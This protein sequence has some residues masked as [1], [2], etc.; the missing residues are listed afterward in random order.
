MISYPYS[1]A[2]A[3]R[4]FLTGS[5]MRFALSTAVASLALLSLLCGS[6]V[7]QRRGRREIE[8]LKE[9]AD[10]GTLKGNERFLRENRARSDYVGPDR[11]ELDAFIGRVQGRVD[12]P[13]GSSIDGVRRRVDRSETVN[14]PLPPNGMFQMYHPRID[15]NLSDGFSANPV[16]GDVVA[17]SALDTLVDS[18]RLSGS[19]R[20]SVSVVDRTAILRGEVPS[21]GARRTAALLLSFEPGISSIQNELTVNPQLKAGA[22]SLQ[23]LRRREENE[24]AWMTLSQAPTATTESAESAQ[25]AS[26]SSGSR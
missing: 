17:S 13:I 15:L 8:A 7:A 20:I 26:I 14:Q 23:A 24:E 21:A 11:N 3:L 5:R 10:T 12:A 19:S 2:S 1:K 4:V 22:D 6:A 9:L 18:S 25:W 16:G